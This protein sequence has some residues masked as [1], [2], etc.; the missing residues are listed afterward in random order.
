MPF[1]SPA[2]DR[3]LDD[4]LAKE[5]EKAKTRAKHTPP[6]KVLPDHTKSRPE[7]RAD[8]PGWDPSLAIFKPLPA[9]PAPQ[10]QTSPLAAQ[11]GG[12]RGI[13]QS[14]QPARADGTSQPAQGGGNPLDRYGPARRRR[15]LTDPL[16]VGG[17]FFGKGAGLKEDDM[18]GKEASLRIVGRQV[19]K[20]A[21]RTATSGMVKAAAAASP[22]TSVIYCE[23][24]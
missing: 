18:V 1:R 13:V 2:Q 24:I 9:Q 17:A 16:V 15:L 20:T 19:G 14:G 21:T 6:I 3:A 12:F 5:A 10:G 11:G 8:G 23:I 4:L 22:K 7:K